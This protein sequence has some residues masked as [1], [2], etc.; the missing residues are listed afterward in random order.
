MKYSNATDPRDKIYALLGLM[1]DS[2]K[3]SEL[4][5]LDYSKSVEQVYG[6]VVRQLLREN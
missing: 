2:E 4:L 3:T 5:Q 6:G 1:H